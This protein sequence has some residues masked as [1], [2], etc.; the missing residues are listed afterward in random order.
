MIY[1]CGLFVLGNATFLQ[2]NL[3]IHH[4]AAYHPLKP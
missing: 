3:W 1:M 2:F 4:H